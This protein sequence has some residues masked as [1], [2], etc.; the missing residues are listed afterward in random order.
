MSD[1]LGKL[2]EA[3][4]GSKEFQKQSQE[5]GGMLGKRIDDLNSRVASLQGTVMTL[6]A[7]LDELRQEIREQQAARKPAAEQKRP[8]DP[9]KEGL[10][11]YKKGRYE[12][13]RDQLG[14]YLSGH[15]KGKRVPE[16]HYWRGD[17]FYRLKSYQDAISEF[18]EIIEKY[19]KSPQAADAY[20][21]TGIAF[22]ELGDREKAKLF[23]QEVVSRFPA[24]EQAL[25]AKKRLKP[26]K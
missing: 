4:H 20:L 12:E 19:P 9:F 5:V 21:K 10:A 16:A 1:V 2:D 8:E 6:S 24:S 11:A 26:L 3:Q 7:A 23:L 17:A 13:A 14:K 18:G 15:P 25:S 22:L